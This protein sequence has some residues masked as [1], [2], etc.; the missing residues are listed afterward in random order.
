MRNLRW[1]RIKFTPVYSEATGWCCFLTGIRNDGATFVS[2]T[3]IDRENS[4][5]I[6]FK[7]ARDAV[8]CPLKGMLDEMLRAP[9]DK[10]NVPLDT[11]KGHSGW[12]EQ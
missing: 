9:F 3:E 7:N 2:W 6:T 10:E 11:N 5:G 8:F 12:E 1:L 4:E